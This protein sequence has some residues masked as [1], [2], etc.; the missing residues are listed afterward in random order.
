MDELVHVMEL[1]PRW[2]ERI[3]SEFMAEFFHDNARIQ[4]AVHY[5][6]ANHDVHRY[7]MFVAD[8]SRH[9]P[10]AVLAELAHLILI[11]MR[12]HLCLT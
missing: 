7:R 3:D 11:D 9:D 8:P 10:Y 12:R 1:V 4:F 5:W 6:S 2:T